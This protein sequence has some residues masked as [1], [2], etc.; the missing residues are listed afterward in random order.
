MSLVNS[1]LFQHIFLV[2]KMVRHFYDILFSSTTPCRYNNRSKHFSSGPFL[3]SFHSKQLLDFLS[4]QLT[5]NETSS[6]SAARSATLT[7]S[8]GRALGAPKQWTEGRS[9][10]LV[11]QNNGGQQCRTR[12]SVIGV[13]GP[14]DQTLRL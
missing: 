4:F 9:W 8:G 12:S 10:D 13:A 5:L 6:L 7:G 14:I 1:L 3:F 11:R 2:S